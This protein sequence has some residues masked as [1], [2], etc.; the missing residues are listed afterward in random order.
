MG[1]GNMGQTK[2]YIKLDGFMFK[3]NL[4]KIFFFSHF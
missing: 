2:V 4:N 1:S 3:S